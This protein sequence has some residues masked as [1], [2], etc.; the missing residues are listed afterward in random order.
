MAPSQHSNILVHDRDIFIFCH[1]TAT[2]MRDLIIFQYTDVVLKICGSV[3]FQCT[4]FFPNNLFSIIQVLCRVRF[5]CTLLKGGSHF[6]AWDFGW[7]EFQTIQGVSARTTMETR[8][9]TFLRHPYVFN[10]LCVYNLCMQRFTF[11]IE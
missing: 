2:G 4:S 9:C 3:N 7:D 10:V 1:E 11:Y 6:S 8:A 5:Q